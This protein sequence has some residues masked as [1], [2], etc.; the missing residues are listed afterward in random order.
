MPLGFSVT[1]AAS[2]VLVL[3]TMLAAVGV[4]GLCREILGWDKPGATGAAQVASVIFLLA[5]YFLA[6]ML[7]RNANAEFVALCLAPYPFWGLALIYRGNRH[8]FPLLVLALC[9]S[10]WR[11]TSQP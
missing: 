7:I 1:A 2:V 10:F 4:A 8:G 5:P 11:I 9:W 3:F 6:D